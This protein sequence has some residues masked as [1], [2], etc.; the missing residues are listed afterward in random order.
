MGTDIILIINS[1]GNSHF[2]RS[3]VDRILK[4]I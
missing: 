4:W 2:Q 1:E 3:D